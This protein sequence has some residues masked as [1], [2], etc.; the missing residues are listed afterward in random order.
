MVMCL[1]EIPEAE[2]HKVAFH[3]S[4]WTKKVDT[5]PSKAAA[6]RWLLDCK[7]INTQYT[8]DRAIERYGKVVYPTLP[9]IMAKWLK[10]ASDK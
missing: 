1:A 10:Y 5:D 8:K 4:H 9:S 2:R 6:G 3:H 7:D